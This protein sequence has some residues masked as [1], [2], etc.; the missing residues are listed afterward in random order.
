MGKSLFSELKLVNL[1][2][3]IF[4]KRKINS[5]TIFFYIARD[6]YLISILI[7]LLYTTFKSKRVSIIIIKN[8]YFLYIKK[9]VSSI[10]ISPPILI[11]MSPIKISIFIFNTMKLGF[12]YVYLNSFETYSFISEKNV[13]IFN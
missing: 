6:Q 7:Y 4:I 12:N 9:K 2:K 11:L 8:K 10:K 13:R 1:F 5:S 3:Y